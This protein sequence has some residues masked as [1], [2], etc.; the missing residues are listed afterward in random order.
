M[1]EREEGKKK[2]REEREEG[3]EGEGSQLIKTDTF[4]RENTYDND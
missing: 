1:E 2:G 3:R 4:T